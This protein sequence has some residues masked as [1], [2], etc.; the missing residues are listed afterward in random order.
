MAGEAKVQITSTQIGKVEIP[1]GDLVAVGEQ[2]ISVVTVGQQGPPGAD[3]AAAA[4]LAHVFVQA[5]PSTL[6]IINHNLGFKPDVS[7]SDTTGSIVRAEVQN[8]SLNQTRIYFVLSLAGE[9][10]LS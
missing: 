9:A 5:T 7:V 10:R 6:W 4:S 8:P 1:S 3:G 2:Q